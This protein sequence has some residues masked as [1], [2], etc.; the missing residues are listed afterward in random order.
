MVPPPHRDTRN[1]HLNSKPKPA[2]TNRVLFAASRG[3]ASGFDVPETKSGI[4]RVKRPS[5]EATPL[6]SED[7]D[8]LP[9]A[10]ED[11][12][13]EISGQAIDIPTFA[14]SLAPDA[15]SS[16][17]PAVSNAESEDGVLKACSWA[18][19]QGDQVTM[20]PDYCLTHH[21][22]H[23]EDDEVSICSTDSESAYMYDDSQFYV[24]P[25]TTFR[26]SRKLSSARSKRGRFAFH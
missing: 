16:P 1:V 18:K 23:F 24:R 19:V 9:F 17:S 21:K 10:F 8:N 13:G 15:E 22:F 11:E 14:P 6:P 3:K 25:T 26:P 4:D 5:L 2:E 7:W 12:F 20:S